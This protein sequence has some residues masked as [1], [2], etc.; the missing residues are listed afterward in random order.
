MQGHKEQIK[1]RAEM[2]LSPYV[3]RSR[4]IFFEYNQMK[5]DYLEVHM[6]RKNVSKRIK[7]KFLEISDLSEEL[8]KGLSKMVLLG[9][10]EFLI[11]NYKGIVEYENHRIRVNTTSGEISIEGENLIIN[12]I[13]DDELLV[14]G[15]IKAILIENRD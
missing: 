10:K 14:K 12:E 3:F 5:K 11:E 6:K 1:K 7:N 4:Y 15:K 2:E 8:T 9:N 13:E